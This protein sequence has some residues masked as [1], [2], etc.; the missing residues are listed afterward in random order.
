MNNMRDC[1][2]C[3]ELQWSEGPV[4]GKRMQVQMINKGGQTNDIIVVVPGGGVGPNLSGCDSQYG[5]QWY[6][7]QPSSK[8]VKT[9]ADIGV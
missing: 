3:F 7:S 5:V 1:C 2:K 6:V 4:A 9:L 8:P